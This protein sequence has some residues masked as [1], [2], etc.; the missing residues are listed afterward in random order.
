MQQPPGS[1][2][3]FTPLVLDTQMPQSLNVEWMQFLQAQTNAQNV[4]VFQVSRNMAAAALPPLSVSVSVSSSAAAGTGAAIG[5]AEPPRSSELFISTKTKVL[6]LSQA[7]DIE[8]VFWSLQLLPYWR[9]QTGVLKKT[10]KIVSWTPERVAELETRLGDDA[11]TNVYKTESIR[12]VDIPERKRALPRQCAAARAKRFAGCNRAAAAVDGD[13]ND[14]ASGEKDCAEKPSGPVVVLAQ[15]PTLGIGGD[16]GGALRAYT[17]IPA[18]FKDE[19]KIWAGLCRK[20]ILS[21][22]AKKTNVFY[23]CLSLVLRVEYRGEFREVHAKVFNTGKMEIPGVFNDELLVLSRNLV[24]ESLRPWCGGGALWYLKD[25]SNEDDC[26][27]NVLINS[28]FNCGFFINR[29][30]LLHVLRSDKYKLDCSYDPCMYP[31]VKCKFYF[32]H[33]VGFDVVRQRGVIAEEDWDLKMKSILRGSKYSEVSIMLFRTG[34][35][36]IGAN[37]TEKVIRFIFQF[38]AT[39][40]RDEYAAVAS[41]DGEA[42]ALPE[43][44]RRAAKQ[45]RKTIVISSNADIRNS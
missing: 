28:N 33:E 27:Q 21:C 37:C 2:C 19:R 16:G 5:C 39:V 18:R 43:P 1:P 35:G 45:R 3:T 7:V 25:G 14:H 9:A 32:N 4:S 44:K 13:E 36:L 6:Y 22:R 15:A 31:G 29:E 41:L 40:L 34:S 24:L 38:I 17:V 42:T 26:S 8:S 30:K 12:R 10:I 20:D 11:G 23:N